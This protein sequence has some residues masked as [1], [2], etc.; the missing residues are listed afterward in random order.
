MSLVPGANKQN[1]W[2]PNPIHL[3]AA[4]KIGDLC[5]SLGMEII[6]FQPLIDVEG[7]TKQADRDA[8]VQRVK[9][10]FPYMRALRTDVTYITTNRSY[11]FDSHTEDMKVIAADLAHFADLAAEYSRAD[12][13]PM[14]KIGYEHLSWGSH[15]NTF[16]KAWEAIALANRPNLGFVF[17]TFNFL[18]VEY[19]NPYNPAGHGRI[20]DTPEESLKV[21]HERLAKLVKTIPGEKIYVVQVAD[22]KLVE[23]SSL[24]PPTAATER[25]TPDHE[26]PHRQW[27]T[28]HRLFPNEGALGGYMPV[29]D[30]LAA[31]LATGYKGAFTL[32][33]FNDSIHV[34]EP[35][36][37]PTHAKRS[38]A[39]VEACVADAK[40]VKPFW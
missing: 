12:G 10:Y 19:A 8:A 29:S 6:C 28:S 30:C 23:P 4:K 25:W 35:F 38:F 14:L 2:E 37:V 27:S 1:L 13:G 24:K 26:P 15:I 17:D 34:N 40:L 20:H 18:A 11:D 7:L 9:N 3:A 33:I 22:A 16:D 21:V 32:E 5:A 36:V 31:V 39:G